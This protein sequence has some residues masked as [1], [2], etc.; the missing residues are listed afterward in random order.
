MAQ[1]EHGNPLAGQEAPSTYRRFQQG[2]LRRTSGISTTP[3]QA[4]YLTVLL[5]KMI[6]GLASRNISMLQESEA[7]NIF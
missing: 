4:I 1:Q 7:P 5:T 6:T 2:L 3:K